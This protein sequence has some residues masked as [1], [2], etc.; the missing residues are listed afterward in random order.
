ML[1]YRRKG[2]VDCIGSPAELDRNKTGQHCHRI[3]SRISVIEGAGLHYWGLQCYPV[4]IGQHMV[5]REDAD[6]AG[7]SVLREAS[8]R[9]RVSDGNWRGAASQPYGIV[10]YL[11]PGRLLAAD[12]KHLGLILGQRQDPAHDLTRLDGLVLQQHCEAGIFVVLS[13]RD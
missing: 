2:R 6:M 1:Q 12:E 7:L 9:T 5:V 10:A 3:L 13:C 11:S 8:H 4:D